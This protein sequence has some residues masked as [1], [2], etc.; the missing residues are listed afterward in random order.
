MIRKALRTEDWVEAARLAVVRIFSID[1]VI[2][3][4]VQACCMHIMYTVTCV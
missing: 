4:T 2:M 1:D 3:F